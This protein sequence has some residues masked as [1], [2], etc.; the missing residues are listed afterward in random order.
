MCCRSAAELDI[1]LR[2]LASSGE[3]S[4]AQVIPDVVLGDYPDYDT[5]VGAC[6][7]YRVTGLTSEVYAQS[8]DETPTSE[9]EERL[10]N[11]EQYW[12]K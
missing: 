2:I 3:Q 5:R 6:I 11:L 1:H 12:R 7:V 8:R 4:A 10:R 9:M